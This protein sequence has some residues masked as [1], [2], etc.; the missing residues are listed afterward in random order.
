MADSQPIT[1][2]ASHDTWIDNIGVA[3]QQ[4]PSEMKILAGLRLRAARLVL[5]AQSEKK[6]AADL[7]VTTNAYNNYER[8]VRL[9]DVAMAVRLLELTG[10]GP[11]WIYAGS[12]TGVPFERAQSLRAQLQ[13]LVRTI[14]PPG[15]PASPEPPRPFPGRHRGKKRAEAGCAGGAGDVVPLPRVSA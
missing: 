14:K 1:L 4:L 12:T 15:A 7:G 5:G 13:Q 10:I 9:V 2:D 11:D 3:K 8:G 6:M